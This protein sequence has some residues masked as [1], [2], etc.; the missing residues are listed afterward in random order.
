M[1]IVKLIG[2]LG[3]QLFQYAF[4]RA[5]AAANACEFKLDVSG[6]SVSFPGE[7]RREYALGCFAMQENIASNEESRALCVAAR[8]RFGRAVQIAGRKLLGNWDKRCYYEKGM[9]YQ[10]EAMNVRGDMYFEG[11]WQTERYFQAIASVLRDE[12]KLREQCAIDRSQITSRI[13]STNAVSVH[14]RRGDLV[15]NKRAQRF[16]GL[17]DLSYYERAC[18]YIEQ[19]IIEPHFYVFSDDI[20]W[21][22]ENLAFRSPV[23]YV[24]DGSYADHQELMLMSY[25]SHNIVANSSF[26]WWGAWLNSNP[27]KTVIAPKRWFADAR[28]D[29]SDVVPSIWVRV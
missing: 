21:V 11:Y 1:I 14:V 3:N 12:I 10:Q 9:R 29:T 6:F 27:E 24:S 8:S 28:T 25:C 15:T 13:R 4:A 5:V 23:T 18:A 26:S 17:C 20:P 7:T 2:G 22:K 16:H 19:N